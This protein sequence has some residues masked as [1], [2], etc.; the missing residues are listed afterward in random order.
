MTGHMHLLCSRNGVGQSHIGAQSFR[1][2][3]HLSKPHTDADTLVV[4][5]VNPTAGIFDDD[6]V[7]VKVQVESGARML[8]TTPSASRVYRSRR[9]GMSQIRQCF[10]V[11]HG[12][13]LE[14]LPEPFIP[15]AGARCRQRNE[16]RVEEGG[17]LLYF[18]WLT[19]GRVAS[20]EV[21]A[22]EELVWE[23]DAWVGDKLT[24]RERYRLSPS[25]DSLESLRAAFPAAH[26]ISCIAVGLEKNPLEVLEMLEVEGVYAGGTQLAQGGWVMKLLCRDALAARQALHLLREKLHHSQGSIPARLGRY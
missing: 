24:L 3:L 19:P 14:Y 2:P 21:F 26:Y 20:G 4:N 1:A 18:E 13:F 25:D 6:E 5:L 15:Q 11:K 22:Y 23:T 12:G 9:G 8:V 10:E 16:L 7:E 17:A